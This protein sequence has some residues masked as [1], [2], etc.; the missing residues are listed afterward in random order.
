MVQR[1]CR[2]LLAQVDQPIIVKLLA[3]PITYSFDTQM[4]EA[5]A[6]EPKHRF[7][8]GSETHRPDCRA[9]N[10]AAR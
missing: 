1:F 7:K 5:K 3:R 10:S 9:T 6:K 4:G 2:L 8:L